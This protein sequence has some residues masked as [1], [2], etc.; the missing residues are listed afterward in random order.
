M[1]LIF[2]LTTLFSICAW[3]KWY[4]TVDPYPDLTEEFT[5]EMDI[6]IAKIFFNGKYKNTLSSEARS[7]KDKL[8]KT[9]KKL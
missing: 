6:K 5:H 7:Y 2:D 9:L 1:K 3:N 8:A 4:H